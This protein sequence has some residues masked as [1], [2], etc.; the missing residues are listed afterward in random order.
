[1]QVYR[2]GMKRI[3]RDKG[4]NLKRF[5]DSEWRRIRGRP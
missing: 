3:D 2:E 4:D 5:I 1:M